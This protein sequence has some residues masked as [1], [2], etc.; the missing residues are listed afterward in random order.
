MNHLGLAPPILV[1][2]SH[3]LYQQLSHG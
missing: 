2:I 3:Q 1:N